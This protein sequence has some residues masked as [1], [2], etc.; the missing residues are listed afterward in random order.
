V[1]VALLAGASGAGAAGPSPTASPGLLTWETWQHLPGVFDLGLEAGG[2]G[3]IAQAGAFFKVSRGGASSPITGGGAYSSSGGTEAYFAVSRGEPQGGACRFPNGAIYGIDPRNTKQ[4]LEVDTKN[5]RPRGFATLDGVDSLNGIAFDDTGSFGDH[6]LLVTGPK[7]GGGGKI[8]VAAVDCH[9]G[10]RVITTAAP[11]MEGG[12]AVAPRGFGSHGGELVV[13][14]E[15]SGDIIGVKVDDT[16]SVLAGFKA[17]TGQ[18][19][20]V[21]S[22]GFVPSGFLRNGGTA[23]LSDRGTAN[24]PHGGTDSILRLRSGDLA[25]A[26]VKEGDLL[27]ASEGAGTTV[28]VACSRDCTVR[29]LANGPPSGHIEGHLVFL[30]DQPAA[31][32]ATTPAPELSHPGA[33]PTGGATNAYLAPALTGAGLVV[34]AVAVILVVRRRRSGP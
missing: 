14:D 11:R 32:V 6:R 20:G 9:G 1:A 3:L 25:A 27:V 21:E 22:A 34:L 26:G 29:P 12:I 17:H 10:V 5:G 30:N 4:V 33:I 13:P 16:S 31:G 28:V 19:V 24:N 18:D 8:E 7:S 2:S 23:Y 15:I